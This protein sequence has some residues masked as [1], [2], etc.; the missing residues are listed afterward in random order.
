MPKYDASKSKK[1]G[2]SCVYLIIYRGNKLPPFYIGSTFL[3]RIKDGY[4][5]T[6]SSKKYKAKWNNEIKNHPEKFALRIISTFETRPA[7][8]IYEEYIQR[9]LKVVSNPL[10]VNEAYANRGFENSGVER[11]DDWRTRLSEAGKKMSQ[12]RKRELGEMAKNRNKR[13]WVLRTPSGS[14]IETD[15]NNFTTVYNI[16]LTSLHKSLRDKKPVSRGKTKGWLL[17]EVKSGSN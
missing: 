10:Y 16:N 7:A 17:L 5:G 1:D 14:I 3:H 8:L 11:H 13:I 12:S 6:P 15:N 2:S 9:Q 4:M